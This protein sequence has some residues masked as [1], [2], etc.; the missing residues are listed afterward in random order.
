MS[1]RR[2][3]FPSPPLVFSLPYLETMAKSIPST[4]GAVFLGT[5]IAAVYIPLILHSTDGGTD[6]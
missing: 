6:N 2:F 4:L 1:G 5:S 3:C